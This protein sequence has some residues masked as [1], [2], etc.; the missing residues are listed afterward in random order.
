MTIETW[1][2]RGHWPK[3]HT[4]YPDGIEH[5]PAL[6]RH[7]TVTERDQAQSLITAMQGRRGGRERAGDSFAQL[8]VGGQLWMSDTQDE[9]NDHWEIVH[10]AKGD[11]LIGGL[12][13]GLVALACAMKD[14]VDS[15][16]V[17]EINPDVAALVRPH[18][19]AVTDKVTIIV[20]DLFA[21][22]PPKGTKYNAIWFDI[23]ADICTENLS[24]YTKLNRKFARARK[25]DGYRGAWVEGLLRYQLQ[26]DKRDD[27]GGYRWW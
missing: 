12:G 4:V 3:M 16:T 25:P 6:I 19:D 7:Y 20:A 15:V 8:L 21:W 2:D 9:R 1:R 27:R 5:G 11:V 22:K 17:I 23:W 24:E 13:L 14:E 18:L 26:R 10:Q